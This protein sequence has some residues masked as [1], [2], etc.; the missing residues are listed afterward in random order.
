MKISNETGQFSDHF[1]WNVFYSQTHLN[2][3]LSKHKKGP[4]SKNEQMLF[5]RVTANLAKNPFKIV[6]SGILLLAACHKKHN[7]LV[8]CPYLF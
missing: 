7:K 8:L 5:L 3:D 1:Q 6:S 4:N 2:T